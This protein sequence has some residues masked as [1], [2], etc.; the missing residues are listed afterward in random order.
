MFMLVSGLRYDRNVAGLL[1]RPFRRSDFQN[2]FVQSSRHALDG[3]CLLEFKLPKE[4][5]AEI[6]EKLG[7]DGS[8]AKSA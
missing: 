1:G 4:P 3:D 8:A 6:A 5:F 7:L 2:A